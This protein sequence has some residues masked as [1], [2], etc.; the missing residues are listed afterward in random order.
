MSKGVMGRID[1]P[2]IYLYSY[3]LTLMMIAVHESS[4]IVA[5]WGGGLILFTAWYIEV[6]CE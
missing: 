5:V 4:A 3:A 2:H 6:D 1:R